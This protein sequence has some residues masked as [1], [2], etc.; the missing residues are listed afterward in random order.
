MHN[1]KWRTLSEA[2]VSLTRQLAEDSHSWVRRRTKMVHSLRQLSVLGEPAAISA[3]SYYLYD[4]D[5]A[6]AEEAALAVD[7]LIAATPAELLAAVDERI[8]AESY[9]GFQSKSWRADAFRLIERFRGG[10]AYLAAVG[11]ASC[12]ASGYVREA[13]VETLDR[14]ITSGAEIPFLLLRLDDWVPAV[15]LAAEHAVRH[16]LTHSHREAY[17]RVLGPI[18]QLRSRFRA[19]KS[20]AL[21]DVENLLR[22]DVQALG[23][24]RPDLREP[25]RAPVW[26]VT[27][28]GGSQSPRFRNSGCGAG[29]SDHRRRSRSKTPARAVADCGPNRSGVATTFP[30]AAPRRSFC[31]GPASGA[32]LVRNA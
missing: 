10:R 32:W 20:P 21:A 6:V 26:F 27:R 28:A 5:S 15:R 19:G 14:E 2:G 30:T 7:S 31:C 13:A 24:R 12:H 22:G 3:I 4:D 16:R 23:G 29:A 9:Y 25:P 11:V 8:R 1:V 18:A 17:L